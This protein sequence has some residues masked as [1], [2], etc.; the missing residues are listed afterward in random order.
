MNSDE[1]E[2]AA[3]EVKIEDPTLHRPVEVEAVP[4]ARRQELPSVVLSGTEVVAL[5]G[6]VLGV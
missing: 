1:I 4:L 5:L 3:K 6:A 2:G